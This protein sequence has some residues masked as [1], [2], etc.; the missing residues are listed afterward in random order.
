M[1]KNKIT[2]GTTA[3]NKIVT[4]YDKKVQKRKEA[5]KRAKKQK[6]I[7][8]FTSVAVL[9]AIVVFIICAVVTNYNKVHK[10]YIEVDNTPVSQI[11]FDFYYAVAK[12]NMLNTALY[13]TMTYADYFTSYMGYDTSKSDAGQTYASTENTWYDYFA[14][15]AVTTIKEYKALNKAADDAGFTYDTFDEDYKTFTEDVAAQANE[16]GISIKEAYRQLFGKHATESN[17]KEYLDTYLKA[18]AYQEQLDTELAATDEEV[19]AYYAENKSDYDTVDYR[20]FNVAAET[21]DDTASMAAAKKT[22]EQMAAAVTDEASFAQLCT[23]YAV[24]D[25]DKETYADT[26]ASLSTKATKAS[27]STALSDWLFAEGRTAGEVTV[28]EDTEN[29]QYTVLYFVNR[30]Y[31]SANDETIANQLLS[32]SYSELIK[33]YTDTM[34]VENTRNRIKMLS[35]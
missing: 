5:E 27:L 16:A 14:N 19:A 2:S 12:S 4:K 11:E 17:L 20:S 29:S 25:E 3:E 33:G 6:K 18:A 31:D 34:E 26:A 24:T 35:E 32:E 21:A 9:T 30:S 10:K 13:G 22:A 28:V 8:I 7:A 1:A 23:Q 15:S